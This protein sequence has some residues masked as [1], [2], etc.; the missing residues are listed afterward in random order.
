LS[1]IP[2]YG[3]NLTFCYRNAILNAKEEFGMDNYL[4]IERLK[5][6]GISFDKGLSDEEFAKIESVLGVHF[7]SEIKSFLA[8]GLPV[9]DHFFNWRDLS[10]S[11]IQKHHD[12][13]H[14]IY[15]A[16]QFDLENNLDDLQALL[17]ESLSG[18]AVLDYLRRSARLIPF[19]A[20]RCFFDGMDHMPIV[21]FWQPVD[22]IF[23]GENF[24]DYLEVEFLGKAHCINHI[25]EQMKE[26]GIW[27]YII[28]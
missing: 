27:Y 8:C 23:Y 2:D 18:E 21:S 16:F 3:K 28:G 24:E 9:G 12:F 10:L 17:G 7:P 25:P 26:T 20:H 5:N 1:M 15:N 22:S 11:N 13:Q 19:Y 4:M 14:S 6:A